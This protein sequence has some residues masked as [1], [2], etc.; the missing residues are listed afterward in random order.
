MQNQ[1][2]EAWWYVAVACAAL[3]TVRQTS[4]HLL[5]E[6]FDA[7]KTYMD[8]L[9]NCSSLIKDAPGYSK[10]LDFIREG[11]VNPQAVHF[12]QFT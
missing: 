6:Y 8:Y 12:P 2:R 7:E 3:T 11:A 9:R 5:V 4:A 10:H 1:T